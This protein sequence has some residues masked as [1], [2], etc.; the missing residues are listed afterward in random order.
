MNQVDFFLYFCV[1]LHRQ[2]IVIFERLI[3]YT[4]NSITMKKNYFLLLVLIIAGLASNQFIQAQNKGAWVNQVISVN[5]GKS[6]SPPYTDFVTVQSYNPTTQVVTV[7]DT[8]YTQSAQD[9]VI[10]GNLAYV[11]AQDSIILYNINNYERIAAIADSGLS[12]LAV[13]KNRLVVSK[14][15]PVTRFFIEILD[16]SNLAL[17][18]RIP[19]IPGDCGGITSALDTVFVSVNGGAFA[20]EGK[21]AVINTANWTLA[22][23]L[24]F[25]PDAVGSWMPYAYGGKVFNINKT[26]FGAPNVGSISVYDIY[27]HYTINKVMS[28]K[29]GDGIGMQDNVLYLKMNEGIGSFNMST[30]EII[31]TAI[32][33]DPGSSNHIYILGGAVDNVND[34]MYLNVGN[35]LSFGVGVV[36]TLTGDSVTVFQEGI[37]NVAI[38]LDYRTP[39]GINSNLSGSS[40]LFV[41]P[42][43]AADFL[44]IQYKGTST[45]SEMAIT[46]ITGN[47]ILQKQLNETREIAVV[48]V[49]MLSPGI[50]FVRIKNSSEIITR[51]FI[52]H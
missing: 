20:T 5:G 14:K 46:D 7:F 15:F 9:V 3:K 50:Y 40:E 43:P 17:I 33:D 39:T 6:E 11:A 30:I 19:D 29:I 1:R 2:P 42:N 31:D 52:K 38:A 13:Y 45:L 44:N 25:G 23:I 34:Y 12:K 47:I 27:N 22:R 4:Q 18:S 41:F 51:K 28:V 32:V 49:S 8:I 21:L 35:Q 26:P 48:D 24:N 36:A 10:N 37:N 16:A